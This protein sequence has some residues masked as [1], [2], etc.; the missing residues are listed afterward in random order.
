MAKDREMSNWCLMPL[1]GSGFEHNLPIGRTT[2]GRD[3]TCNIKIGVP[4]VSRKHCIITISQFDQV[5]I[6]DW[7]SN[8]L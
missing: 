5:E 8:F 1:R 6:I 3:V 4:I 7:V 2:V